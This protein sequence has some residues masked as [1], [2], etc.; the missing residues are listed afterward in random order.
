M[1][2]VSLLKLYLIFLKIGAILLGG[3]Y[4]ILPIIKS[5]LAEKRELLTQEE[6]ID[7]YAIS[8]AM[9]GIVA[10]NIS[11]FAGYKLRGKFGAVVAMLGVIT[12][13]FII[14]AL[15]SGIFDIF[16][17]NPFVVGMMKG[18]GVAVVLLIM[19]SVS[20]IFQTSKKDLYFFLIFILSLISLFLLK[21]S[22]VQTILLCLFIGLLYQKFF[23]MG[24][25]V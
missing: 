25:K 2:N 22:P 17:N 13:P 12:V 14:I 3:G 18:V 19:L 11:I 8:Q 21:L 1:Q 10:A 6:L 9:P 5:E 15:I 7:Y 24:D 16:I 20:E 4:V 23:K